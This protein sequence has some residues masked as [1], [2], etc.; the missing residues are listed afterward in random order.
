MIQQAKLTIAETLNNSSVS[1]FGSSVAIKKDTVAVGATGFASVFVFTRYKD[2][3]V[4]QQK[5][6]IQNEAG[7]GWSVAMDE[8]TI[9]VGSPGGGTY[10]GNNY[11]FASGAA[12]IFAWDG[13]KWVQQA[14]LTATDA[15]ENVW[16]GRSVAIYKD[17]VVVG[18]P[19]D[20]SGSFGAVYVFARDGNTWQEKLKLMDGSNQGIK[21][22]IYRGSLYLQRVLKGLDAFSPNAWIMNI[23]GGYRYPSLSIEGPAITITD[24]LIAVG[25]YESYT[26]GEPA[27]FV[28]ELDKLSNIK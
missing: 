25:D 19:K 8:S 5:L 9:V 18:A 22:A 14:K 28:Y 7:C 10:V 11:M 1:Y 23:Q 4:E 13:E 16:L 6:S 24:N 26:G 15:S 12:Y 3:W 20:A 2:T 17:R 21:Q 27:V